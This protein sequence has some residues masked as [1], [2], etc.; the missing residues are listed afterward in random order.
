M[1]T[2]LIV[3]DDDR[4][5]LLLK[6]YLQQNG[7][8]VLE[9]DNGLYIDQKIKG[10]DLVI[11]DVMMPKI[12]G[13]D[14]MEKISAI[15]PTLPVIFLSAKSEVHDRISGLE[16]G[17]YDYI[18]KPFDPKELLLR[19]NSILKRGPVKNQTDPYTYDKHAG[20][21]IFGE[22]KIELSSTENLLFRLLFEN[23]NSPVRRETIIEK[24][25]GTISERSV[26]V[27]VTRIRKKL[28]KHANLIKTV[29]H[30]GYMLIT[31]EIDSL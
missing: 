22:E 12:S 24:S 3:D 18:A 10:I 13:L 20:I 17:A 11:L 21:L 4:I 2:I 30:N 5:R 16:L 6:E 28:G 8:E 27:Q 31:S 7:F 1:K 9:S 19:I 29:R 25:E 15:A 26:D 14:V 23:I